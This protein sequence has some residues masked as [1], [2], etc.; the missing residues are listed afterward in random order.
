MKGTPAHRDTTTAYPRCGHSDDQ[1]LDLPTDPGRSD[2]LDCRRCGR[3]LRLLRE[4]LSPPAAGPVEPSG[5]R[6]NRFSPLASD[7]GT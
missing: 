3:Q 2:G 7:A 4:M 6:P 1:R 5:D